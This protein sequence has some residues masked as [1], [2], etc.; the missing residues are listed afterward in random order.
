MSDN[1]RKDG[2]LKVV[3][4][5]GCFD[6]LDVTQEELDELMVE[7]EA[8][9][10]NVTNEELAAMSRPLTDEDFDEMPEEIQAQLES[11]GKGRNLQ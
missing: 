7:L 2:P 10:N 9:F 11:F 3:F 5:P 1:D 8:K 6:H 4:A